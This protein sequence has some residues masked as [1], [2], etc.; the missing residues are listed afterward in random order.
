MAQINIRID[1]E[2]K[3]KAEALFAELG[4]TMSAA[5][6][7]FVKQSVREGGIPF[8]VSTNP[9]PFYSNSNLMKLEKSIAQA[10]RKEFVYKRFEDLEK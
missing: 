4:I 9:D 8:V 6:T 5:F 7:M 10:E 1:E 2:L 3:E